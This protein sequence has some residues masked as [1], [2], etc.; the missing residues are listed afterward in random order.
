MLDISHEDAACGKRAGVDRKNNASDAKLIRHRTG[1]NRSRPAK[2]QH[3]KIAWIETF[4]EQTDADCRSEIGIGQ[5]KNAG[6]GRIRIE[7]ERLSGSC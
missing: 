1:V 2:A 7:P 3:C 5:T 4:L 6:G